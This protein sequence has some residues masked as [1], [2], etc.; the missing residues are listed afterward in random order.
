MTKKTKDELCHD[1]AKLVRAA[2]E[3]L[4]RAN[5]IPTDCLLLGAHAEIIA[6]MTLHL[7]G[8]KT[9][10]ACDWAAGKVRNLPS[11][12]AAS[13]AFARPTGRA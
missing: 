4:Q 5:D 6:A 8:P 1:A 9:A 12:H 10:M 7:G 2:L 11:A 3:N 13:L